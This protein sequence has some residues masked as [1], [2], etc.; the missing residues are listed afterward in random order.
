MKL[1]PKDIVETTLANRTLTTLSSALAAAGLVKQFQGPGPF[2]LF[3]PSDEA[4][5]K[6]PEDKLDALMRDKK[7][8]AAVINYHTLRGTLKTSD[9]PDGTAKT[10]EGNLLTIGATDEGM[11]V[12]HANVTTPNIASRNGV[13]HVI[14]TVMMPGAEGDV[15][16]KPDLHES[17][18]SGRR[19]APPRP[20]SF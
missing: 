6:L 19:R 18:W 8:L 7:R 12:D 11:R 15:P 20:R 17:P 3:A 16:P 4:F 10:I 14:D 5:L 2:T 1:P 9:L 13:I